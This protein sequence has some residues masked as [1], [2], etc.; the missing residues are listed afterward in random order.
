MIRSTLYLLM[1][2]LLLTLAACQPK[3]KTVTDIVNI[4]STA[5]EGLDKDEL[6]EMEFKEEVYDFGVITQGEKVSYEFVFTNTGNSDLVISNAYADCGCTVPEVPKQPIPP[7]E[8][9][10]IRVTF[11]SDKKS[12]L[13]TKEIS[14]MTNCIPA[15]KVVKIKANVFVPNS[16]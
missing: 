15:R 1:S 11:D 3:E 6:P 9:N 5:D 2:A 4:P 8:K 12:G 13:I 14:I 7:G 10:K 16:K